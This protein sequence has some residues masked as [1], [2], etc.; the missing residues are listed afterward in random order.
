[1]K[2]SNSLSEKKFAI[3][4]LGLSGRSTLKFLKKIKAKKLYQWDDSKK[5]KN[6]ITFHN[7]SKALT[8]VDYII[9]SP[10][11]DIKKSKFKSILF[12]KKNKII[13]DLD[14]FYMQKI[15]RCK[16]IVVTGTNGKSTTCKLIEHVLKKNKKDVCL[17]GNIGKPILDLNIKKNSI[18]IIE[19][20]SFQLAYSKFINPSYAAIINISK[21][22]L[23]WHFTMA[24]YRNSKFKIFSNQTKNNYAFLNK[25]KLITF[26]KKKKFRSKLK[27]IKLSSYNKLKKNITNAYLLSKTNEENVLF[28]FSILTTLGIKKKF[29]LKSINSFRGLPHRHEIF[30]KIKKVTF[31]NDSKATSFE[32][33]KH[34]LRSNKNIFWIL[35]GLHKL[36]D[37]IKLKGL[38]RE[39]YQSICYR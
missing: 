25:K 30:Y 31:I 4:G 6:N 3:Y 15:N 18:V 14:L 27:I 29:I 21:D 23:D 16:S 36:N 38:S 28:A 39:Y 13:T 8:E 12:K 33:A 2:L 37:K 22:H 11:I 19:A 35:G 32:S 26:F 5:I 20:S 7:F 24:N 34:A 17:G 10:G 1:M 9:I